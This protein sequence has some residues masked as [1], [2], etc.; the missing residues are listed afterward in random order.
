MAA[1]DQANEIV[2]S[3]AD[4]RPRLADVVA[5]AACTPEQTEQGLVGLIRA[6]MEGARSGL[7]KVQRENRDEVLRQAVDALGDG[8]SRAALA[9]KLALEEAVSNS[10]KFTNEDLARLRDDV[11]AVGELFAETVERALTAGKALTA[12]QTQAAVTHA[13]RVAERIGD[14]FAP[15]LDAVRKHP[16]AF[17]QTGVNAGQYAIGSLFQTLSR[18]LGQAGEEL[19]KRAEG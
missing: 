9:G 5:T 10:R 12:E 17:A 3:G 19:K 4:V 15:V 16:V 6:V 1:R 18:M 2:A 8:L 14:V 13:R 11:T 7:A